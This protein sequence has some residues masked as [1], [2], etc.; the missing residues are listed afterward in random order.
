MGRQ[1]GGRSESL[2]MLTSLLASKEVAL[3]LT[4]IEEEG[5]EASVVV[6]VASD[7]LA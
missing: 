4:S 6:K 1:V 2:C 7:S 3:Y 5:A